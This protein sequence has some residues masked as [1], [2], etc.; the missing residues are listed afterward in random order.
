MT[1]KY[2]PSDFYPNEKLYR[3]FN[4]S[5]LIPDTTEIGVHSIRFPDFSCNWSRFSKPADIRLRENINTTDGCYSFTVE[6]SRFERMATPCHDPLDSNYAHVEVRQLKAD[7]SIEFEPP[8][9][10][11]LRSN[12]WS[13]SRRLLYRQNIINDLTVEIKIG[14]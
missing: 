14:T 11:K 3:S 4:Q 12:N 9:N 6:T 5:D 8:K 13:K 10:R 1:Y 7:E 2:S